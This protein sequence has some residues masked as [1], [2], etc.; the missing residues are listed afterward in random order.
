MGTF[1]TQWMPRG[2]TLFQPGDSLAAS[3]LRPSAF[4]ANTLASTSLSGSSLGGSSLGD[5]AAATENPFQTYGRETSSLIQAALQKTPPQ[6]RAEVLKAIL[7]A[8]DPKLYWQVKKDEKAGASL[9]KALEKAM[10]SGIAKDIIELGKGKKVAKAK[11]IRNAARSRH[12]KGVSGYVAVGGLVS[13]LTGLVSS[14]VDAIGGAGCKVANNSLTPAVAAGVS[15]VYGGGPQTGAAGAMVARSLCAKDA[16][17]PPPVPFYERPSFLWPAV[18]LFG[19]GVIVV[20]G[21]RKKKS[22]S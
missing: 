20:V 19:A 14:T 8:V 5:T 13:G 1:T 16:P 2:T 11:Q 17:P 18:A 22:Q 10:S 21:I 15:T 12:R 3:S 7:D 4:S 6:Q 9:N